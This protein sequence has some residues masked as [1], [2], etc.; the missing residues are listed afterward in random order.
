MSEAERRRAGIRSLP[1][2]LLDAIRI[3]ENS[4]LV[5]DC[6]GDKVFE[7]FI[8]NKKMEWDEYKTQITQ[9]EIG[10]YLPIL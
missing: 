8:R 1:E 6:L 5:R 3:T 9:Y 7:Y 2:D 4:P 10:K